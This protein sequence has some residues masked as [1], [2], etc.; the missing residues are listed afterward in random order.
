MSL[1]EIIETQATIIDLQNKL[2][3]KFGAAL[4][5]ALSYND[6]VERI[7]KLKEKL[8]QEEGDRGF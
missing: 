1:D 2:I 6:E 4:N 3:R 5:L 8:R 7:R